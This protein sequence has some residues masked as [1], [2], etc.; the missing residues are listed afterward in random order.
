[1]GGEPNTYDDDDLDAI[2]AYKNLRI[3]ELEAQ[4]AGFVALKMFAGTLA[5]HVLG[6][7]AMPTDAS[8]AI[9]TDWAKKVAAAVA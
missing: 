6:H 1:M 2:L 4:L 8:V 9:C 5:V 7:F 3:A